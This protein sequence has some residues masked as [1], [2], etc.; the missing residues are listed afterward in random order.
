MNIKRFLIISF[1]IAIYLFPASSQASTNAS[2]LTSSDTEIGYTVYPSEGDQLLLWFYSEAGPQKSDLLLA[3]QISQLGIEVWL[4]DLFDSYF[5]PVAL[6]SMD[7]IPARD[8]SDLISLADKK[9]K[10][11]VFAVTTGRAAIPLLRGAR[12]LQTSQPD[13]SALAGLILISPKLF[14]ETPD[15]GLQAE[16][17][18]IV[19]NTNLLLFVMQPSNSP[20]FWKMDTTLPALE[21]SGS[22][23]FVQRIKDVRDRFYFRPDADASEQQM[24]TK[25]PE[26]LFKAVTALDKFPAVA[27]KVSARTIQ[28]PDVISTKKEKTL[29]PHKGNATPPE[30]NLLTIND[31]RIGLRSIKN[32]VVLVNFWASWCPPCV[33]EMPSMQRLQD[34]FDKDQFVILGVNMAE[35][36]S[37]IKEFLRTK[38]SV[39]FPL[40][41]DSDGAALQRWSVFAFPT[42]YIIDKKGQ[43]RYSLFGSIEW[44]TKEVM[45]IFEQLINE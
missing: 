5:L 28:T 26:M 13:N 36:K 11:N 41:M 37:I 22:D 4:I 39:S 3:Q 25:L 10:K 34:T 19:K 15:P 44:D 43:I 7:K 17:M 31:Q 38:V 27:R 33:H 9:S 18:P 42:S 6:S 24:T 45:T 8:I 12:E 32:K 20:W 29:N 35:E 40:L 2:I 23:V 30:L 16:L 21:N 1:S 14:T